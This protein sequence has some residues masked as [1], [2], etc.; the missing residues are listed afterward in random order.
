[1]SPIDAIAPGQPGTTNRTTSAAPTS[2]TPI[3]ARVT[4]DAAVTGGGGQQ[5]ATAYDAEPV[6]AKSGATGFLDAVDN[7]YRQSSA[8]T[9]ERSIAAI[10]AKGSLGD[11]GA[12]LRD[13]ADLGVFSK[14]DLTELAQAG[15]SGKEFGQLHDMAAQE[16]V[17]N[18]VG[19]TADSATAPAPGVDAGSAQAPTAE[20]IAAQANG[21]GTTGQA[22][23]PSDIPAQPAAP[24]DATG[25]TQMDNVTSGPAIL[26]GSP[27]AV[28]AEQRWDGDLRLAFQKAGASE[29]TANTM[30][31]DAIAGGMDDAGYQQLYT[32]LQTPQGATDIAAYEA[33][34]GAGA[35]DPATGQ[36]VEQAPAVQGPSAWSDAWADKLRTVLKAQG[37]T[38]QA[39]VMA[40]TMLK[41][42]GPDETQLQAM[43]EQ[44]SGPQ[45]AAGVAELN[46]EAAA[47][48]KAEF[49]MSLISLGA[50]TVGVGIGATAWIAKSKSNLGKQITRLSQE[51]HINSTAFKASTTLLDKTASAEA[52]TAARAAARIELLKQADA[53]NAAGDTKAAKAALKAANGLRLA[54]KLTAAQALEFGVT[55]TPP[56][57]HT[58]TTLKTAGAVAKAESAALK[59]AT[60][61]GATAIEAATKAT[62]AGGELAFK[63]AGMLAKVG[64]VLGPVGIAAGAAFGIW[65][66]SKTVKAE[67]HFGKESAKKTGE[68]AG[69]LAGGVGGAA[70]GAIVGQALI[71]VPVV[72]ALI[73][74]AVGGFLGSTVGGWLGSMLGGGAH[75]AIAGASDVQGKAK[76]AA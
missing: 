39:V 55:Y 53:F 10:Q 29:Q 30:I 25:S 27:E 75:D 5:V 58:S 57:A 21:T 65:D 31:N 33:Q 1:M 43:L 8:Q 26:A 71:P 41:Q 28:A 17:R 52:R 67:G 32:Y 37:A 19:D 59:S 6:I 11:R 42:V 22:P 56:A 62:V 72:G 15:L 16:I 38:D 68:V 60:K 70:A 9:H 45:G 12:T 63:G 3:D 49:K 40:M 2:A 66:I 23:T 44:L 35:V 13:L 7:G 14:A 51:S 46:A 20:D 54:P 69:S 47:G 34:V 50:V 48:K 76:A 4:P 18:Y 73:G 74:G 36:P 61:S 24:G 64:K